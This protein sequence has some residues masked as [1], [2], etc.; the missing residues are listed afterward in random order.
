MATTEQIPAR[1]PVRDHMPLNGI[2]HVELWVG[3]AAQAAYF[4]THAYGFRPVAYAGLETGA[5]DRTSHVLEQGRVRLVVT[6]TLRSGTD[7]AAHHA[8]HGDGVKVIALSVPDVPDAYAEATA[9]GAAGLAEPRWLEDD[10]GRVCIADIATYGDTVH[11]F[12]DRSD[13]YGPF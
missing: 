7:I 1:T 2:D 11:R 9:R 3:N 13:Y 12:V 6:G 4:F 10:Q 8:L 5:R